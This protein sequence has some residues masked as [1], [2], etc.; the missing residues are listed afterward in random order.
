MRI[1]FEDEELKRL[2]EDPTYRPKKWSV[3]VVKAYRKKLQILCS[4]TDERDLYAMR[5]LHLEQLQGDR[6]G[7]S[8]IR[9]NKK[10]RLI[11]KFATEDDGRIVIV[12]ELVDYH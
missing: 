10:F 8:S 5:S 12:I 9:L 6:R 11:L 3:D 1:R 2:A 4:A 7:T